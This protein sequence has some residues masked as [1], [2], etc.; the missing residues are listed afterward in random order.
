MNYVEKVFDGFHYY[1][2]DLNAATLS[3]AIDTIVIP[4]EVAIQIPIVE[5]NSSS[6]ISYL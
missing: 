4:A 6:Y 5:I 3:G 2:F 1:F